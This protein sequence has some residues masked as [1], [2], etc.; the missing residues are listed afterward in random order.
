MIYD[1][2]IVGAGVTGAMAARELS[3]YDLS[4]CLLEAANDVACGA[5]RANSGIVHGGFDPEP[6]TLKARLN[7]EGVPLLYEAARQLHVPVQNNGSLVCAFSEEELPALRALYDRG[8]R[9]GVE[10][11]ALLTGTRPEP[12]SRTSPPPSPARCF[13][14]PPA[15]SAPTS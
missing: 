12:W 1:I 8:L 15:S 3:R 14:P 9:N 13:R 10:Q 7:V 2:L 6:G 4:V 5:S 11:L